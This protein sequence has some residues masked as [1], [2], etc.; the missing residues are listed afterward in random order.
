MTERKDG[1][2]CMRW[3]SVG[4]RQPACSLRRDASPSHRTSGFC[5]PQ[6]LAPLAN[7]I[8]ACSTGCPLTIRRCGAG[9]NFICS[10]HMA[11]FPPAL[12]IVGDA[13]R[14]SAW[15]E[16]RK[17]RTYATDLSKMYNTLQLCWATILNGLRIREIHKR[18]AKACKYRVNRRRSI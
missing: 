17:H 3:S 8:S 1:R 15:G 16:R 6:T 11:P 7:I 18:Y 12:A 10:V 5:A 4:R 14:R 13:Q 2:H 9:T